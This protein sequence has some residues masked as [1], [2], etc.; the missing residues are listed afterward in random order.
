MSIFEK[1]I[2]RIKKVMTVFLIF[3][4]IF[5][6]IKNLICVLRTHINDIQYIYIYFLDKKIVH[7]YVSSSTVPFPNDIRDGVK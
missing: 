4:K 6:K 5:S 1:K 3:D 7:F 2:L